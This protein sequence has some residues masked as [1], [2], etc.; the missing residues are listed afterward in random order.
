VTADMPK[1]D[2][3]MERIACEIDAINDEQEVY[4]HQG[5]RGIRNKNH[6]KH[7]LFG[8]YHRIRETAKYIS[9]V[10]PGKKILNIGPGYGF[11]D[12][13]LKEDFALDLTEM[14]IEENIPAYCLLSKLH[15]IPIIPGELSKKQCSIADSSFDIV[16]FSEVIEHLR[17]STLRALLEIKRILKSGGRLLLTTPNMARL[18][19][20]L[21]LLMGRNVVEEFPDDDSQLNHITDKMT[22]ICEYT[23]NELKSLMGRAGFEIAEAKYSLS[24]DKLGPG[25]VSNWK[26]KFARLLLLPPLKL[27]PSLRSPI[28]IVGQKTE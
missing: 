6:A 9:P 21:R 2:K 17:I 28:F 12:I 10:R 1:F 25:Q 27:V 22:H 26:Y 4:D 7:S 23:M 24:H 8:G 5:G 20:I 16:I 18:T 11:L 14:E 19:T 15:G 13:I 3:T